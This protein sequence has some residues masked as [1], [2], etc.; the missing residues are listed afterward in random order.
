MAKRKAG[1]LPDE[2]AAVLTELRSDVQSLRQLAVQVAASYP[3][4]RAAEAFKRAEA[5]V[6][7]FVRELEGESV[8]LSEADTANRSR[9][10][11][12]FAEHRAAAVRLHQ[13]TDSVGSLFVR[14]ANS[15]GVS[16]KV[17]KVGQRASR[18]ITPL[19]L[20]L[21]DIVASEYPHDPDAYK[22]YSR[23]F[24]EKST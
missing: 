13:L 17:A 1:L 8:L 4:S 9:G 21:E 15:Y 7:A 10:A 11:F 19:S 2:L 22:V 12:T 14:T 3:K 6:A 16:S 5:A 23:Y 18:S 24:V 20:R